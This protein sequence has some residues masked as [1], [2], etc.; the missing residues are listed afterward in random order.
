[1]GVR[2]RWIAAVGD[3]AVSAEQLD[4]EDVAGEVRHVVADRV[5][6]PVRDSLSAGH[7]FE[8]GLLRRSIMRR[9][10]RG[11]LGRPSGG[12]PVQPDDAVIAAA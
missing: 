7:D 10:Q 3:D 1:M 11:I 4:P 5:G 9:R 2:A 8:T 12:Q 6:V